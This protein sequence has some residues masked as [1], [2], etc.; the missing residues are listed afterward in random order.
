[1]YNG[2]VGIIWQ[3][4][5]TCGNTHLMAYFEN[6]NSTGQADVMKTFI[7]SRLPNFET[8]YAMT[9]HKT[10]GSEF[11]HVAMAIS[12][13]QQDQEREGKASK[14]LSREL[15]YTGI[16]RAKSMLTIAV[17]KSIWKQGVTAQVK[18]YS[19]LSLSKPL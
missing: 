9:I 19:G 3:L 10:Q 13:N 2:D 1:L 14:L 7:P 6:N 12:A 17:D 18:R 4:E 15:L 16:T 11:S 8:V 5:N